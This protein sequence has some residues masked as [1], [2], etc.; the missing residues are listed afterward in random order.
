MQSDHGPEE[1][2]WHQCRDQHP[3]E[4]RQTRLAGTGQGW[5]RWQQ[6]QVQE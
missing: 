1:S 2:D 5:R 6:Q 4:L 3:C